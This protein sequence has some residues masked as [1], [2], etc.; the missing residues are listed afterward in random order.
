MN[1]ETIDTKMTASQPK[2]EIVPNQAAQLQFDENP[3][4]VIAEAKQKAQLLK[5]IASSQNLSVKIGQG[6]H[7][8]FEA[9]Q[10]IAAFYGVVPS[11]EEADPIYSD[12]KSTVIGAKAVAH[13]V[14][15]ED[16]SVISK[17]TA[18]CMRNEKNWKGRDFHALASMAQTRAGSKVL[19]Q[20]FSW[21][22]I[23]AG[24]SPTPA[25]EVR[26]DTPFEVEAREV[27]RDQEAPYYEVSGETVKVHNAFPIKQDLK[28]AG[29]RWSSSSKTWDGANSRETLEVLEA[30]GVGNG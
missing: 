13:A 4:K 21:V 12:D 27:S 20:M 19:K 24:Y 15:V 10:T 11:I 1:K 14:K 8:R 7:L 28:Q 29:F 26:Q 6:N 3:T 23:L 16:G 18:F 9:W 17:A 25:E 30:M 5:E 22:V 2:L